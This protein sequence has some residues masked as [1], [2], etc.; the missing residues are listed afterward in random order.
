MN[1]PVVPM[2]WCFSAVVWLV[3][4]GSVLSWGCAAP[5]VRTPWGTELSAAQR[6]QL[7]QAALKD[8][9][10]NAGPQGY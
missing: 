1:L 7:R 6:Q 8:P 2:R 4:L 10:P 5:V 3:V 9:F